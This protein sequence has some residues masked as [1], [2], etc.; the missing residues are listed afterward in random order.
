M[1]CRGKAC[2]GLESNPVVLSSVTGGEWS[3]PPRFWFLAGEESDI[4][5]IHFVMLGM[6]PGSRLCFFVAGGGSDG[7]DVGLVRG[8]EGSEILAQV[9]DV[10][11]VHTVSFVSSSVCLLA[12]RDLL[13][14]NM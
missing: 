2:V 6:G 1:G 4:S 3:S 11:K 9:L 7:C 14:E 10:A 13:T 5:F 12:R 8:W